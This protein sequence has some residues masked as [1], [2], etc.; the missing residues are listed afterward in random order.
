MDMNMNVLK[1][2]TGKVDPQ[3]ALRMTAFWGDDSWRQAAYSTTDNLFG[4]E[5]KAN[6]PKNAFAIGIPI[7]SSLSR[8]WLICRY[9]S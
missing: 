9:K 3:Q 6:N 2:D 8:H 1:K 4:I 5:E 7:E